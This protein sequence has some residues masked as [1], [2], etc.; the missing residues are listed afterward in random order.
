MQ[1]GR[2]RYKARYVEVSGK[3]DAAA[4]RVQGA[5]SMYGKPNQAHEP[6]GIPAREHGTCR[7]L[8]REGGLS[9]LRTAAAAVGDGPAGGRLVF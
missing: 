4:C 7:C 3:A 8:R 6:E 2:L 9:I 1:A 5:Q